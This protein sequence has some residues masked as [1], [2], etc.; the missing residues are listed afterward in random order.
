[1]SKKKSDKISTQIKKLMDLGLWSYSIQPPDEQTLERLHSLEL[2]IQKRKL[3][4][5]LP[6]NNASHV[7]KQAQLQYEAKSREKRV[8]KLEKIRDRKAQ[9]TEWDEFKKGNFV[10]LGKSVSHWLNKREERTEKLL[11]LGLPSLPTAK[12]LAEF[13]GVSIPKLK[14]LCYQRSVSP[15][16]QYIEFKIPKKSGGK[17]TISKPKEDLRQILNRLNQE[18]FDKLKFESEVMGF[19]KNKSHVKNAH[20]HRLAEVIINVDIK[21]FFP[22]VN[23]Y[24]VRS[25][26]HALGYSGEISTVLALL[27]TIQ[28]SKR[29][30]LNDKNMY[31]Y[32][33]ERNLPQGSCTSPNLANLVFS[34]VDIQLKKR[35]IDLG[36]KYT[37]YADDLT[38][39]AVRPVKNIRQMMYMIR[40]TLV[41]HGYKANSKKTKILGKN[42]SQN[43]T[44][45]IINSGRPKI[46]RVWRRKLRAAI[47]QYQNSDNQE[48][49]DTELP[50]LLGS[51]NYLR[52][53]H[54][55]IASLYRVFLRPD[56]Y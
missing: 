33:D 44:G 1:M 4:L 18:I 19:V 37:R 23:F 6:A 48:F 15:I 28:P 38:F 34:K 54:P 43:V 42:K 35:S 53:T 20:E 11:E 25:A 13:L 41:L 29:I 24:K 12:A 14:H 17:R 50:R 10:H 9:R 2:D 40:K 16:C 55:K 36:Y 3:Q 8:Q 22:S 39:S 27:T 26:I 47:Y 21:D 31:L 7:L 45:I 51:V 5:Y 52:A 56:K 32:K 30:K 46:P 49:K